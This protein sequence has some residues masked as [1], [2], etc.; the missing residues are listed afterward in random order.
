LVAGTL[1]IRDAAIDSAVLM[2]ISK[3]VP[4]DNDFH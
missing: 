4:I 1:S 2:A 3:R